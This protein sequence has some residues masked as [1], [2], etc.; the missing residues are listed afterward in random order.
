MI[1]CFYD[2][3]Q[4][5][6]HL[7]QNFSAY[8]YQV[9]IQQTFHLFQLQEHHGQLTSALVLCQSDYCDCYFD[10]AVHSIIT[11]PLTNKYRHV[12]PA[13]L[14]SHY[15]QVSQFS[16]SSSHGIFWPIEKSDHR[17]LQRC[18]ASFTNLFPLT[19][20]F[21]GVSPLDYPKVGKQV[22]P[23]LTFQSL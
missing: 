23:T 19:N 2:S 18:W 12:A 1:F 13:S 17:A 8:K 7:N 9:R 10:S 4:T 14:G 15:I 20:L 3:R 21:P 16:G 11:L 6:A 22:K 5:F